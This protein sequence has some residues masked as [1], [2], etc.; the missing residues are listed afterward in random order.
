MSC[1]NNVFMHICIWHKPTSYISNVTLIQA[2]PYIYKHKEYFV[3]LLF[4]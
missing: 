2:V 1:E 4:H 3:L